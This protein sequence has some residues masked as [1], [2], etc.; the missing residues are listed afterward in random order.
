MSALEYKSSMKIKWLIGFVIFPSLFLA[1]CKS[2]DGVA[3]TP[4]LTEKPIIKN[5]SP[6]ALPTNTPLTIPTRGS[7][8]LIPSIVST[9]FKPTIVPT[10]EPTPISISIPAKYEL[11]NWVSDP[12]ST[13]TLM[14]S[15]IKGNIYKL[16]FLNLGTKESFDILVSSD[17]IRGYFW[18]PDGK[19]FGFLSSLAKMIF[20]IDISSG[21][22][23]QYPVTENAIRFLSDDALG[24]IGPLIA[25]GRYQKDNFY[26]LPA[27][28]GY[29]YDHFPAY[30]S[31]DLKYMA[32]EHYEEVNHPYIVIEDLMTRKTTQFT[33][34]L[35]NFVEWQ[36]SWSP[37]ISNLEI[38]Q[39]PVDYDSMPPRVPQGDKIVIY[40]PSGEVVASFDGDFTDPVWSPDGRKILYKETT[41][42][43]PCI[44]AIET[45]V[46][47]CIR[48]IEKDHPNSDTI[49]KFIWSRAGDRIFYIFYAYRETIATGLCVY[50][51]TNG[52]DFCPTTGLSGTD[53]DNLK[54]AYVE[55]Y[56]VSP[57]EHFFVFNFGG[58]TVESDDWGD[59]YTLVLSADG[60]LS[61]SLGDEILTLDSPSLFSY[62]MG[63][64]VWRPD[65]EQKP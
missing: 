47:K 15:D 11:P 33:S 10:V 58:S 57:D 31:A 51:L 60:K 45:G 63:S 4:T 2:H 6:P 40:Q 50:N 25:Y 19:H 23:E 49:I 14:I 53:A 17:V 56:V 34:P 28:H 39:A 24:Y 43:S 61:Y 21:N 22:V 8:V 7:T 38:L 35:D 59:P 36:F 3:Q 46:T 29:S 30:I 42:N 52:D 55:R 44:L 27:F 37:V 5:T 1:G 62:P 18:T 48:K 65:I 20:L 64:F 12:K 13:V 16:S 54:I 41:S 9:L 26:L 32:S